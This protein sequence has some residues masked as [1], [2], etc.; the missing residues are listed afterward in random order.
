M[1]ADALCPSGQKKHA[2]P[3]YV[4]W[5]GVLHEARERFNQAQSDFY[6]TKMGELMHESSLP[7]LPRANG[8]SPTRLPPCWVENGSP[9]SQRCPSMSALQFFENLKLTKQEKQDRRRAP[10]RDPANGSNFLKDVG[11]HYLSLDRTAPTLSGGESQRV[12]LASQIGSGLVG[13]TYILDEPSIG[14][15]PRD[16]LKLLETLKLSATKATPSS[17]S[18]TM[19]RR[20]A[21]PITSSMWGLSQDS[22]ADEIIVQGSLKDLLNLAKLDH[23]RLPLGTP[24]DPH[25][26]KAAQSD[27]EILKIEKASHHN[28]KNVDCGNP[29]G[30]FVAV[31]GVSGSGKSSLITDML[32][33][34]SLQHAACNRSSPVGKHKKITGIEALDKVIAIDQTP[35]GRTPRSNPATYIKLFDEIRDLFSQL[36]ESVGSRL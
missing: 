13:A 3:S 32:Y 16:N 31:T 27:K 18:S 26:K 28:L 6:R 8:S 36:P 15:H 25:P 35:I 24:L 19:K 12:R 14:L 11:L 7:R 2:G 17:S 4:Q 22:T 5:R 30:L 29:A 9:R 23:R 20:S 1:D 34:G 21:L 10:Q 33:P